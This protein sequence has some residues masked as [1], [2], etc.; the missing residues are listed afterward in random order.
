MSV[1]YMQIFQHFFL[2]LSQLAACWI[3]QD[4]VQLRTRYQDDDPILRGIVHMQTS[5]AE[6]TRDNIY[7]A[8]CKTNHYLFKSQ[9]FF[10][11]LTNQ[12]CIV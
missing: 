8:F 2:L 1:V 4:I 11:L 9:C 3:V 6:D 10:K 5:L 12:F 7:L